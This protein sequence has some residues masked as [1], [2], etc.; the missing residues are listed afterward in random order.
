MP[1]SLTQRREEY[2]A[3]LFNL[4]NQEEIG[5][6]KARPISPRRTADDEKK[7]YVIKEVVIN[8]ATKRELAGEHVRIQLWS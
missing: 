6:V 3:H 2:T 4:N 8:L 1:L 7:K 5:T